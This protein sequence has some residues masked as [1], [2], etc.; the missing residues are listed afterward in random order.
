MAFLYNAMAS[1][2]QFPADSF[3]M[4]GLGETK[5]SYLTDIKTGGCF[6]LF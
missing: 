3:E 6:L 1:N 2:L 4:N 5:I